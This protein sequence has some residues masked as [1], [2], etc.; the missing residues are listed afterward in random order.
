MVD[1]KLTIRIKGYISP[2]KLNQGLR[3]LGELIINRVKQNV[4]D[5]GLIS[6]AGGEYLQGWVSDVKGNV[7]R[8]ENTKE[9]AQYLEYGTYSYWLEHGLYSY[10]DP[11]QPKK[12][13]LRPSVRALY[14]KGMQAFAPL[15]RVIFNEAIM[16][17]LALEAFT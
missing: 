12:K 7:I 1:I 6:E 4:R 2:D 10:T 3:I 5:M 13:D 9:Y 8:V 14:P 16:A 11:V 15:R 17:E